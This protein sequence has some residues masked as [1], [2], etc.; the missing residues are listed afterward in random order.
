MVEVGGF[1]M[2]GSVWLVW[3]NS[4]LCRTCRLIGAAG[5]AQEAGLDDDVSGTVGVGA[6]KRSVGGGGARVCVSERDQLFLMPVSMR[7]SVDGAFWHGSSSTWSV[8][9]RRARCIGVR[10]GAGAA[11][12]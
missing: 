3:H 11:T 6:G 4:L 1:F 7:D 5:Y 9:S 2:A 10:W 12:L 8:S